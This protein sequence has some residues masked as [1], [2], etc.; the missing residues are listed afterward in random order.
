MERPA[1][2]L[3]SLKCIVLPSPK[4]AFWSKRLLKSTIGFDLIQAFGAPERRQDFIK[5]YIEYGSCL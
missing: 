3:G 2:Q 5:L 4:V 1:T